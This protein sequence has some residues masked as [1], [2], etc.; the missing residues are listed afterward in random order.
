MYQKG[1]AY[2]LGTAEDDAITTVLA[3]KHPRIDVLRAAAGYT[4]M[5]CQRVL[6][7]ADITPGNQFQHVWQVLRDG[8]GKGF[9]PAIDQLL[10]EQAAIPNHSDLVYLPEGRTTAIGLEGFAH[11]WMAYRETRN[12]ALEVLHWTRIVGQLLHNDC[13][14]IDLLSNYLDDSVLTLMQ[15][16]Q[17]FRAD[18]NP[19]QP[20]IQHQKGEWVKMMAG[21]ITAGW[22]AAHAT[23]LEGD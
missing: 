6:T 7:L 13:S 10:Q 22:T 17:Q 8:V 1:H 3:G 5:L 21:C 15:C 14:M 16:D 18:P 11:G 12:K 9:P 19:A 20:G 4:V 23:S 2:I